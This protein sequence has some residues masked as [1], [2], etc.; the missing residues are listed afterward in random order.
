MDDVLVKRNTVD[1]KCLKM[2]C[3][4]KRYNQYSIK[5]DFMFA[6]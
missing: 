6:I 2:F 4:L 3:K 5:D 1:I